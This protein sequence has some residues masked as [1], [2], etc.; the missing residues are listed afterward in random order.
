MLM[1][2]LV[3]LLSRYPR[4]SDALVRVWW[5]VLRWR[6]AWEVWRSGRR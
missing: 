5:K 3:V 2:R 4:V 6:E 1:R